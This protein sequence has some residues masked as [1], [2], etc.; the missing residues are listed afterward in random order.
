[1]IVW[2]TQRIPLTSSLVDNLVLNTFNVKTIVDFISP[3]YTVGFVYSRVISALS[4]RYLD[5]F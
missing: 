2:R 4:A 1:M 3:P 5:A